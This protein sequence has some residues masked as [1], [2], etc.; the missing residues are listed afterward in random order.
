M[1]ESVAAI[2]W[3][4]INFAREHAVRCPPNFPFLS[5]QQLCDNKRNLWH[6]HTEDREQL[7]TDEDRAEAM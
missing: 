5:S 3:E 2:E 6:I 4:G 1:T 7:I